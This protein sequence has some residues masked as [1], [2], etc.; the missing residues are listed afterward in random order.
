MASA[1]WIFHV[2]CASKK[3]YNGDRDEVGLSCMG[4]FVRK[5]IQQ[6]VENESA[7]DLLDSGDHAQ[8]DSLEG[9]AYH[10]CTQIE[11]CN[12]PKRKCWK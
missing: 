2:Y 8:L 12:I 1:I 3:L 5:V 4:L 7:L 9:H 11:V 6:L 10:S